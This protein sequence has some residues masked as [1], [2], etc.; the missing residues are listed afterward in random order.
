M[1]SLN[2]VAR[3]CTGDGSFTLDVREYES[4][5]IENM[6]NSGTNGTSTIKADGTTV[7]SLA[8]TTTPI[9]NYTL[10]VSQYDEIVIRITG[11]STNS[12]CHLSITNLRLS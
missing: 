3:S 1:P 8:N 7:K 5:T 2:M 6:G 10:D 12:G 4:L 11:S 9:T